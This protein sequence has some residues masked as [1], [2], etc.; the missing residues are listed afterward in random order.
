MGKSSKLYG[1]GV[2][3]LVLGGAGLSEKITSG[4]GSDLISMIVFA[5]GFGLILMSYVNPDKKHDDTRKL[6]IRGRK[7]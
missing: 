5:I 6:L 4:R 7:R 3:L 2:L 1:V